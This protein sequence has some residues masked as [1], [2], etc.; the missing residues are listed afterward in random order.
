MNRKLTLAFVFIFSASIAFCSTP[1]SLHAKKV[2]NH[3]QLL[4]G[5]YATESVLS[6][7]INGMKPYYMATGQINNV[8]NLKELFYTQKLKLS[9]LY[10]Y[11]IGF[12]YAAGLSKNIGINTGLNYFTYGYAAMG[13]YD[14]C[15]ECIGID[16]NLTYS[17]HKLVF[18]SAL[19]I[20]LHLLVYQKYN[21]GNLIFSTGPDFYFPINTFGEVYIT[22][23]YEPG[24][25][26]KSNI[27]YRVATTN[28]FRG[29]SLGYSAGLGFEKTL[30][31]KLMIELLP[32]FSLLNAVPFD[33]EG[34]GKGI[35]QNY[36]FNTAFG[37]NTY[38]TFTK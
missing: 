17:F 2:T 9:P 23:A 8:G 5:N 12:S 29:G 36:I 19:Q 35:Y 15:P 10:S 37:L 18:A 21:Y 34:Q 13:A 26:I 24:E 16:V 38:L 3:F 14:A 4:I 1:D 27:N 11:N 6:H 30:S 31:K 33:F 20:P 7:N 25:I 22:P 28:F 32:E